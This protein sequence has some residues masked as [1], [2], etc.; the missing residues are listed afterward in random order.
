MGLSITPPEHEDKFGSPIKSART[1][2][3]QK[4]LEVAD[5]GH[6]NE[7]GNNNQQPLD[8]YKYERN[9][10]SS[11]KYSSGTDK[12]HPTIETEEAKQS[13]LVMRKKSKVRRI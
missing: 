13:S 12:V 1:D 4:K 2:K 6:E 11:A 3:K 8:V 9:V 10:I 7:E 5:I